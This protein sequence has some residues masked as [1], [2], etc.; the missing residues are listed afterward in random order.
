MRFNLCD[1][2]GDELAGWIKSVGGVLLLSMPPIVLIII[3]A[4]LSGCSVDTTASG[5]PDYHVERRGVPKGGSGGVSN[6]IDTKP[7]SIYVE[8]DAGIDADNPVAQ[9]G[10]G[11]TGG[12]VVTTA[13]FD[14]YVPAGNGGES[15]FDGWAGGIG[16]VGGF[17]GTAGGSAGA[18]GGI[19][20]NVGD[21]CDLPEDTPFDCHA[22]ECEGD[23]TVEVI[24]DTDAQPWNRDHP[25]WP[26]PSP[27]KPNCK[28]VDCLDG[29][30]STLNR[31]EC[32]RDYGETW[33]SG[34]C[35]WCFQG[36]AYTF[37]CNDPTASS[38]WKNVCP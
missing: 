10:N 18:V 4:W 28:Y 7:D 26:D 20:G 30:V 36:T 1:E 25:L 32:Y 23:T 2:I 14:G 11:G 9:G 34:V 17:G 16:A 6:I 35:F 19:D 38:A 8:V 5:R 12:T 27:T 37:G 21:T 3:A 29:E 13:G 33:G 31:S 24:D 22:W 15:G